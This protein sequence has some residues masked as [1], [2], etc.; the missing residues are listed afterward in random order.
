MP[1][2]TAASHGGMGG[3]TAEAWL[4]SLGE[5]A[6]RHE[7]LNAVSWNLQRQRLAGRCGRRTV[8]CRMAT[9]VS[10]V[11]DARATV[12]PGRALRCRREGAAL[13]GEGRRL[14]GVRGSERVNR[15]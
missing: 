12:G 9:F 4:C 14:E 11:C 13:K 15:D 3:G 7:R 5:A 10:A 6:A 2:R 8:P 1:A